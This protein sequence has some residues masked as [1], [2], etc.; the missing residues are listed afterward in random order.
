MR[1]IVKSGVNVVDISDGDRVYKIENLR[2]DPMVF[3]MMAVRLMRNH[4]ESAKKSDGLLKAYEQKR[5]HAKEGANGTPFTRMLPAWLTWDER[6]RK[7]IVIPERADIIRD[8]FKSVGKRKG[9]HWHRS[10]VRRILTNSV[11]VG[12]FTPHRALTDETGKRVRRPQSRLRT[13]G[14]GSRSASCSKC[15]S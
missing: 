14:R 4:E 8:I 12:T 7:H 2:A 11:V 13:T 5:A 3:L 15:V 6:T 9:A 10:Y 1:D